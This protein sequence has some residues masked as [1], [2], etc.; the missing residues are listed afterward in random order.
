MECPKC[1]NRKTS[2][3]VIQGGNSCHVIRSRFC[4]KCKN[5]FTTIEKCKY[6]ADSCIAIIGLPIWSTQMITESIVERRRMLGDRKVYTFETVY[7]E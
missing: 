1:A 4:D 7:L 6:D 3:R 5:S 2:F